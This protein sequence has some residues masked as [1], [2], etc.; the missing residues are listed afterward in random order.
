MGRGRYWEIKTETVGKLM[1]GKAHPESF[2]Q[3]LWGAKRKQL[4]AE[5]AEV[6]GRR[7]KYLNS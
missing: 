6:S 2:R 7:R 5:G 3:W 4:V 1:D